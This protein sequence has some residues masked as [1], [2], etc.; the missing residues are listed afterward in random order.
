[1]L[2]VTAPTVRAARQG[3]G[4]F[5]RRYRDSGRAYAPIFRGGGRDG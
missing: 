1:V 4:R 3:W 2:R 5:L